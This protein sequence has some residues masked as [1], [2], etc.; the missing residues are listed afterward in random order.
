MGIL[1]T[2][3][4]AIMVTTS[5]LAWWLS[6]YDARVT[7]EDKRADLKRRAIRC[8][9]T[10]L[11]VGV[12]FGAVL[13]GGMSGGFVFIANALPLAIVWGGCLSEMA[14][15]CVQWL[16]DPHDSRA[17]DSRK[18]AFELDNIARQ[19]QEGKHQE[20]IRAC[21]TLLNAG[22]VSGLAM[23]AMLFRL[24]SKMFDESQL[25]TSGPLL[26]AHQLCRAG[27]SADAASALSLLVERE[28]G[29]LAAVAMLLRL[30]TRDLA[31][32]DK[33]QALLQTIQRRREI[34][35]GFIDYARQSIG[36]W[37]SSAP[38]PEQGQHG[39]ESLLVPSKQ[40]E[41]SLPVGEVATSSIQQLLETGHLGTAI[42]HLERLANLQPE[43]FDAWLMLAEAHGRYCRNAGLASAIV[44]RME[45]NPAFNSAQIQMARTKLVEWQ[46]VLKSRV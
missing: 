46:A 28:P 35:P 38:R 18:L 2:K 10:L 3:L 11:L 6:G 31:R 39:I 17:V 13:G 19:V 16:I 27:R 44:A 40:A 34:P 1:V 24:Y 32:P 8:G 33:A 26:E 23:E 36:E 4:L 41:S 9:A 29:N 15:R 30:Y 43:N 7:G 21:T 37:S 20:A 45:K 22:E 25:A 12:G 42:E 14:A 5:L